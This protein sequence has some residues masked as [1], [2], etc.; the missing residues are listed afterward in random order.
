MTSPGQIAEC[1]AATLNADNTTRIQAEL[2]LAEY[3]A[4]PGTSP[5]F[6]VT[7]LEQTDSGSPFLVPRGWI[8]VIAARRRTGCR[9]CPQT[10]ESNALLGR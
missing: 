8:G 7:R 2:K 4:F 6:P 1:L 5:S 3:L 9:Y 10:D